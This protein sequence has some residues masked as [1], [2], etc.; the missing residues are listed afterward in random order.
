MVDYLTPQKWLGYSNALH[1]FADNYQLLM[2]LF[3]GIEAMIP[4][5]GKANYMHKNDRGQTC[6]T[7]AI[8]AR[9][10]NSV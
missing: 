4:E 2:Q 1:Y 7:I 3:M 5:V 10:L 6:M 9:D 8:R